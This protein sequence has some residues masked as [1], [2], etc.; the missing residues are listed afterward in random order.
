MFYDRRSSSP[1]GGRYLNRYVLYW[2]L[3]LPKKFCQI[4]CSCCLSRRQ[5]FVVRRF[6]Q[7][8]FETVCFRPPASCAY[9]LGF[10]IK[11]VIFSHYDVIIIKLI[12]RSRSLRFFSFSVKFFITC[13]CHFMFIA[14]V[15]I[16]VH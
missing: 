5:L 11:S 12:N 9:D 7:S 15:K 4:S 3:L 1:V 13:F 14:S 6:R 2:L 10:A 16:R 8:I